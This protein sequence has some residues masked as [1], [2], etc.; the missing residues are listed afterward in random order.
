MSSDC[1]A[2]FLRRALGLVLWS[3]VP[4][5]NSNHR[6]VG[7]LWVGWDICDGKALMEEESIAPAGHNIVIG[8]MRP[9]QGAD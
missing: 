8:F 9:M 2:L 7:C 6:N 1:F 4:G 3:V 5:S